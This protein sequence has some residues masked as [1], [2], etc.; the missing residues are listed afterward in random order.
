M[1]SKVETKPPILIYRQ[2]VRVT[3]KKSPIVPYPPINN[4][5]S[6]VLMEKNE[7][8][9]ESIHQFGMSDLEKGISNSKFVRFATTNKP[10][11]MGRGSR[12]LIVFFRYSILGFLCSC[13]RICV[14]NYS[15]HSENGN[16][17]CQLRNPVKNT[18][19]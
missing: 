14:H 9:N 15:I 3:N 2:P 12:P 17:M 8:M 5:K 1:T 19:I 11:V 4:T 7:S 6:S 10:S 13:D 16:G 18:S